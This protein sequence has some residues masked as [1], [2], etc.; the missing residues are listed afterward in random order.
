M[1]DQD[2]YMEPV[3][4]SILKKEAIYFMLNYFDNDL[5]VPELRTLIFLGR[6]VAG[7]NDALLYFQDVES[8]IRLGP[9]PTSIEGRGDILYCTDDQLQ[10]FFTL[11]KAVL[12]LQDCVAR[13]VKKS[14]PNMIINWC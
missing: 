2:L 5:L 1:N 6:N 9:Y 13:R 7:E 3:D 10:C 12:A 11:E 8:Y 14:V 4:V